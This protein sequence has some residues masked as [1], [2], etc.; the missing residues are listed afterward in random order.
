MDRDYIR[1]VAGL[2]RRAG[3]RGVRGEIGERNAAAER[4]ANLP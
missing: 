3:V 1:L 2:A 4:L